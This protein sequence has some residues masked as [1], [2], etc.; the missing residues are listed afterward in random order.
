LA[1]GV[2]VGFVL[3]IACTNVANLLFARSIGRSQEFGVR[4]ALGARRGR[5]VRQILTESAVLAIAGGATGGM[6]A[7]WCIS[8]LLS[9]LPSI[10]PAIA[11]IEINGRLLLFSF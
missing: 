6:I 8:A 10:L 1:L 3:L 11:Q 2:A 4:I 5:L 9:L 7:S